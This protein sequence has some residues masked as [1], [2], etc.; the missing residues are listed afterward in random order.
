[1]PIDIFK[2]IEYAS[3]VAIDIVIKEIDNDQGEKIT[4]KLISKHLQVVKLILFF[5]FKWIKKLLYHIF[6]L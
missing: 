6:H 1:M 3:M 5:H 2:Y 4:W